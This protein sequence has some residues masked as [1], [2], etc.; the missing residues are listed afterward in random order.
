M[1]DTPE[2]DPKAEKADGKSS[3]T[4]DE[5]NQIVAD[6]LK[7]EREK[8]GDIKEL[9]AAAEELSA[10]KESQKSDAEKQAERVRALELD[11]EKARGEAMRLRV[12]A[13]YGIS[14]DDADLFLTGSDEDTL[15]RQAKR[16]TDRESEKK[17]QGNFVP[18]EGNNP[19]TG[20][21]ADREVVK[22]LFA[23]D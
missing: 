8:V 19:Q 13:R 5:V 10:I 17:K 22:R 1:S 21:T 18:R 11:A 23:G 14:D 4:Q 6:R 3:F 20:D 2:Q 12:A 9:R 16:L 15:T 7:R